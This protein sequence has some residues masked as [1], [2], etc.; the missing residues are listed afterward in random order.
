MK[1]YNLITPKP[2]EWNAVEENPTGSWVRYDDVP[3]LMPEHLFTSDECYA[4]LELVQA[5]PRFGLSEHDSKMRS[6]LF[7]KLHALSA[8]ANTK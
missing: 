2:P 8:A 3:V 5:I 6:S 4:L 1:R 7:S